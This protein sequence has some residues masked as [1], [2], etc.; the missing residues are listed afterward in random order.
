MHAHIHGCAQ[1]LAYKHVGVVLFQ[2]GPYSDVS[3]ITTAAGPPGQCR[4][5]CVSFTPDGCVLVSWEVSQTQV[6]HHFPSL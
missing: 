6:P 2:Y 5:P 4:A 1:T 3:E